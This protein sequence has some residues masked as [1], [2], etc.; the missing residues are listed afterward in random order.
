MNAARLRFFATMAFGTLLLSFVFRDETLGILLV[1]MRTLTAQAA[2]IGIEATGLESIRLGSSLY[3]PG[4]FAIQI[5]RGCTGFV[6]ATLLALGVIAYPA[7]RHRRTIGLAVVVPLFLATNLV[8]LV[9]LYHLGV[10]RS[11]HFDQA[12]EVLWQVALVVIAVGSWAAWVA[13]V[14]RRPPP[15]LPPCP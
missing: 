3:H 15:T 9:H 6:G 10:A 14:E 2:R 4:G 11:P 7:S 12:H 8:R 5:S 13:W 1:G